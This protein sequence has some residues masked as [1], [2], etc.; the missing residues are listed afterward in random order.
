[1]AM[2]TLNP[3]SPHA[4]I[5]YCKLATPAMSAKPLSCCFCYIVNDVFKVQSLLGINGD[6]KL[7]EVIA[8]LLQGGEGG[9]ILEGRCSDNFALNHVHHQDVIHEHVRERGVPHGSV[10]V[11]DA[12]RLHGL[13]EGL[14]STEAGDTL[15]KER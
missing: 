12:I 15:V 6:L 11:L 2:D 8:R 3:H 4:V 13:V 7:H 1:M 9:T 10:S 14:C 5:H